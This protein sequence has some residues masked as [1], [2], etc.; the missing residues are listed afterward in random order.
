MYW[1]LHLKFGLVESENWY[2]L[3]GG[4]VEEDIGVVAVDGN[5]AQNQHSF[6]SDQLCLQNVTAVHC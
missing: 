3:L 5:L 6:Q 4:S 1:N 2:L